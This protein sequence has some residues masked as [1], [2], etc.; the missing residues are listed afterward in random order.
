MGDSRHNR[1]DITFGIILVSLGVLFLLNT[2]DLLGFNIWTLLV[3]GWP[4]FLILIG[5]NILFRGTRLWWITPLLIIIIFIGLLFPTARN[6]IYWNL[7]GHPGRR[8]ESQT[9]RLSAQMMFDPGIEKLDVNMQVDAGTIDIRSLLEEDNGEEKLYD[10]AFEYQEVEPDIEYNFDSEAGEGTLDV[11]QRQR[12]ELERVDII[13]H[14]FL[15][16]HGE[17]PLKLSI[18]AGAGH[19]DLD[20]RDLQVDNLDIRSGVSDL[21]IHFNNYSSEVNI[22]SGASNIKFYLPR[23][24]GVKINTENVVSE[25]NFEEFG[26]EEIDASTFK[27]EDFES[28]D[29]KIRIFISSPASNINLEH[30]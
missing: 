27:S 6:P 15:A 10:L 9:E 16:L 13:N 22:N 11:H 8:V 24:T 21:T 14:A 4:L 17:I 28:R 30:Y 25:D 2:F 5:L 7:V 18:K 29:E 3:R 19:Y 12:F 23:D 20:L 1:A 26:L